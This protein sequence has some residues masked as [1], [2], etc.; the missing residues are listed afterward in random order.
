MNWPAHDKM[1]LTLKEWRK[2]FVFGSETVGQ[3]DLHMLSPFLKIMLSVYYLYKTY[4]AECTTDTPLLLE[5]CG[6]HS[7][8]Q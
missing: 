2:D 5:G 6:T 3:I 8:E 7:H 4:F 1:V